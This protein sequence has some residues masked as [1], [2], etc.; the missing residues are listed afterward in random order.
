MTTA[1]PPATPPAAPITVRRR[2]TPVTILAV[3][4][5]IGATGYLLSVATLAGAELDILQ[6]LAERGL[7]IINTT[8]LAS[9]TLVTALVA[10]AIVGYTAAILLFRMRRL[11]WTLTMLLTGWS[12]A[13]Q[14]YLYVTGGDLVPAIMAVPV[15]TALYLNQRQ[16]RA[17]FGIGGATAATHPELDE[18]A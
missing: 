8:T 16:V 13:S 10:M 1:P 3:I 4:Q 9:T 18:R 14:I 2:P 6:S 5:A 12:L 7:R 15:I 11:G 17:A